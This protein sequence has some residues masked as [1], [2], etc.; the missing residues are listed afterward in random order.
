MK[1]L[2][3][4]TNDVFD[5]MLPKLVKRLNASRACECYILTLKIEFY[6]FS[7]TFD[8]YIEN[9]KKTGT[10]TFDETQYYAFDSL[11][12]ILENYRGTF[13]FDKQGKPENSLQIAN[14]LLNV[15]RKFFKQGQKMF[16]LTGVKNI[17][18]QKF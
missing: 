5:Q 11:F 2:P 8:L 12:D 1:K 7:L 18:F 13:Y 15:L 6:G 9:C 17:T 16:S 4:H 3:T 10:I 14:K